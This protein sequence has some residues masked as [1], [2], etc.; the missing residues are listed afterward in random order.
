MVASLVVYFA[1]LLAAATYKRR[2]A[3]EEDYFLAG[4]AMP[5]W[6]LGLAFVATWYGGNSALISVDD[7]FHN[8][9]SSW[10]I[11]GGPTVIAVVALIF[12]APAIRRV[13]SVSQNGIMA[14]RYNATSGNLLSIVLTVYLIVWGASQMVAI[15]HFFVSFFG[16]S[17]ALAVLIGTAVS[18]VY[19]LIGGFRAV[20]LTESIQF[21]LLLAGLI[22]TMVVA[23]VLSG[24][25]DD[26]GRAADAARD[27][28]YFNLFSGIG[29]NLTYII[30][31]GLAF[32][33][34]GAAWQRIQAARNPRSAR[35]TAVTA[36]GGFVPLYFF[37]VITGIAALAVFD[38]APADGIVST[39]A[40]DHMSPLLGSIVF[41]GVAAAIMSTICTTFNVGSLYMTEL[42][43]KYARPD[44]TERSKVRIGMVGTM[45][46]ATAGFLVA[47]KLPSA[48]HLLALA[49]EM[50]AA[51]LFVPMILGFFWRRG[52]SAGAVASIVSGGSFIMYGFVIELGLSLPAFWEGGATRILIGMG[53]SPVV[54]VV[55]SLLTK[56]EYDKADAF[57]SRA[58]GRDAAMSSADA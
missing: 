34:D 28:G 39:L 2:T 9:M 20:V 16:I 24:G 42:F 35:M 25:F 21:V 40:S 32:T 7:A 31:F 33:I 11:L 44:A 5:A 15:G 27:P 46:A 49:S 53:L 17:Y 38:E 29:S 8:G 50:L 54:Y 13:G 4:R 37:V 56:P 45:I 1:V 58:F 41:V 6:S 23:L 22:V 52:T 47:V 43:V 10:W 26:I 36:M 3:T 57:Q 19:A 30:S 48:L 18:L 14:S 12:L 55:V 51:G